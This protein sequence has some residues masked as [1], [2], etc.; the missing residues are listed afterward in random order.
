MKSKH[1]KSRQ[2][3]KPAGGDDVTKEISDLGKKIESALKAA[4]TN[5]HVRGIQSEITKGVRNVGKH[6][7]G[8]LDAARESEESAEL[9]KQVKKVLQTGKTK[10]AEA[11]KKVASNL[12]SGLTTLSKELSRLAGKLDK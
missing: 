10:G 8:A 4:S 3:A 9:Q 7:A 5:K 12:V 2:S 6:L 1:E 11:S